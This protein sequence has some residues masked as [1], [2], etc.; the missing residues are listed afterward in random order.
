MSKKAK[1]IL[2]IVITTVIIAISATITISLIQHNDR[3][4][5]SAASKSSTA[6]T[7]S[8]KRSQK[9][10]D[11]PDELDAN[12]KQVI[13]DVEKISASIINYTANNRGKFPDTPERLRQFNDSYGKFLPTHPITGKPYVITTAPDAATDVQLHVGYLCTSSASTELTADSSPSSYAVTTTLPSG[14]PHCQP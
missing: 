7:P 14:A 6:S 8:A 5:P 13:D 9:T 2:A 1:I 10:P 11:Q 12:D 3:T 4:T